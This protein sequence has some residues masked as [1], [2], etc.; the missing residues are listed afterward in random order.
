MFRRQHSSVLPNT[1]RFPKRTH[2]LSVSLY[3]QSF[4]VMQI[5]FLLLLFWVTCAAAWW[6]NWNLLCLDSNSSA[7]YVSR[8][9]SQNKKEHWGE[10]SVLGLTDGKVEHHGLWNKLCWELR[11]DLSLP[12]KFQRKS[13][14]LS[15]LQN[16][17]EMACY[18]SIP[19]QNSLRENGIGWGKHLVQF[20]LEVRADTD[21]APDSLFFFSLSWWFKSS[22]ILRNICNVSVLQMYRG[23]KGLC[24]EKIIS[25]DV[26]LH[27]SGSCHGLNLK[28]CHRLTLFLPTCSHCFGRLLIVLWFQKQVKVELEG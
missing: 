17:K 11:A 13:S 22:F 14:F 1:Q 4:K 15:K 20:L 18:F 21:L 23:E 2:F 6:Q 26:P 7:I 27:Y 3:L 10:V 16:R 28:C 19:E 25:S 9:G 12:L 8:R 5:V 24:L